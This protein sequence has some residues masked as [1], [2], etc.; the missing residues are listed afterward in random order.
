MFVISSYPCE[1]FCH[2]LSQKERI[3]GSICLVLCYLSV[4]KTTSWD[5]LTTPLPCPVNHEAVGGTERDR[6]A[7][8]GTAYCIILTTNHKYI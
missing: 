2:D 7:Q 4:T 5:H 3:T 8:R 1:L 6:A